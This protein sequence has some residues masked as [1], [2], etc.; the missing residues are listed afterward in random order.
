V[1]RCS[2]CGVTRPC[3][4]GGTTQRPLCVFCLARLDAATPRAAAQLS[5]K[6]RRCQ[7]CRKRSQR[8]G[9]RCL[10]CAVE[11]KLSELID[12]S[13]L[14]PELGSLR[15]ALATGDPVS[16]LRWLDG[17][18]Q[19]RLQPLLS[20]EVE[21]SHAGL[22]ELPP[23]KA[24][25]FLRDLLIAAGALEP[26][27]RYARVFG[28]W[29]RDRLGQ[30][31]DPADHRVLHEFATW[32]LLHDLRQRERRSELTYS[33]LSLAKTR[34]RLACE[35]LDWAREQR[36]TLAELRQPQIDEWIAA[37]PSTRR[38]I[39]IFINWTTSKRY[40]AKLTLTRS[41]HRSMPPEIS[42][43][44]RWALAKR[45]L[46]DD[47]VDIADR[48]ASLLILFYG[49]PL[50]RVLVLKR[51][52]VWLDRDDDVW[53]KLG[54][55]ATRLQPPLSQLVLELKD[56]RRIPGVARG[57]ADSEWLF[58]GRR[59]GRPL[60]EARMSKRLRALGLPLRAAR[61]TTLLHLAARVPAPILADL[62]GL[63]P[64]TASAWVEVA[65]GRWSGYAASGPPAGTSRRNARTRS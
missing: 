40:T 23:S 29:T 20:G 19:Q 57:L 55:H 54:R 10:P 39:E 8:I 17:G 27:E 58:I 32:R 1:M 26:T 9:R 42:A 30:V 22:D 48:V 59:P 33:T 56:H 16:V 11:H 65:G 64:H 12:K 47:D 35:L 50:S 2:E 7:D 31:T 51:D 61:S 14:S 36:L 5:P 44:E 34:L 45:L 24:I 43:D 15:A 28:R 53:I 13:P 62:L 52:A 41:R 21:L 37:G 18:G 3:P 63:H 46:E 25:E 38:E 4:N 6:A 60:S 49:Q